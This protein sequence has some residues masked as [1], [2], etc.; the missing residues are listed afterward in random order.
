MKNEKGRVI[1]EDDKSMERNQEWCGVR[2]EQLGHMFSWQAL[3]RL[4]EGSGQL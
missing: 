2:T 1:M 4:T 3:R